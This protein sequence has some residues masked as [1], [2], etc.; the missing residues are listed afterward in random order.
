MDGEREDGQM[1]KDCK[2]K[3]MELTGTKAPE[4]GQPM[5]PEPH[6]T[7]IRIIHALLFS[8]PWGTLWYRADVQGK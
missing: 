6:R 5:R 8:R 3:W 1:D 4:Q 2:W 7:V